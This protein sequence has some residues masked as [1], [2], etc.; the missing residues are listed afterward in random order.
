MNQDFVLTEISLV[1]LDVLWVH[2]DKPVEVGVPSAEFVDVPRELHASAREFLA[3]RRDAFM[4]APVL[5]CRLGLSNTIT[6]RAF[7]LAECR[8]T[9]VL[10]RS[11]GAAQ[12]SDLKSLG[13][14]QGGRAVTILQQRINQK[15]VGGSAV[16]DEVPRR[17]GTQALEASTALFK[18]VHRVLQRGSSALA[19]GSCRLADPQPGPPAKVLD[20][21]PLSQRPSALECREG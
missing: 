1:G 5:R 11:P 8:V 17:P 6:Q 4:V 16:V 7:T 13:V 19:P 21:K 9:D 12:L 10:L 3:E 18:D 2:T 14:D 15:F 20:F